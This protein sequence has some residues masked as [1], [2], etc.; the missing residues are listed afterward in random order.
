M[1]TPEILHS[2]EGTPAFKEV[3]LSREGYFVT[4]YAVNRDGSVHAG[5]LT[6]RPFVSLQDLLDLS[7]RDA[8]EGVGGLFGVRDLDLEPILSGEEEVPE[9]VRDMF[10]RH[11]PAELLELARIP[12][13]EDFNPRLNYHLL[14]DR[15]ARRQIVT[16]LPAIR[17]L[18]QGAPKGSRLL[19][20]VDARKSPEAELRKEL[21]MDEAAFKQIRRVL[22]VQSKAIKGG[23][24]SAWTV[25]DYLNLA[26]LAKILTPNHVVETRKDLAFVVAGA[27]G[28]SFA[29]SGPAAGALS[30]KAFRQAP[31][32]QWAEVSAT[33][34]ALPISARD[35]TNAI[36][37]TLSASFLVHLMRTHAPEAASLLGRI[38]PQVIDGQDVGDDTE[39]Q[40]AGDCCKTLEKLQYD[41]RMMDGAVRDILG[42][43]LSIKKFREYAERWHHNQAGMRQVAMSIETEVEWKPLVGTLDLGGIRFREL[44]SNKH[45]ERQGR[46]QNNCVGGYTDVLI[47]AT[48][49]KLDLIFSVETAGKILSTV[50]LEGSFDEAGKSYIWSVGEHSGHSNRS[51]SAAAENAVEG[52]IEELDRLPADRIAD[53]G[54]AMMRKEGLPQRISSLMES[55][56]ANIF[57]PGL[58]EKLLNAHDAVLPKK[59]RGLAVQDWLAAMDRQ[60]DR[61]E[62]IAGAFRQMEQRLQ[63]IKEKEN[64]RE[65]QP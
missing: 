41:L 25:L 65:Y 62:G 51:P 39:L 44:H 21:N 29:S 49:R 18:F 31:V 11:V 5:V 48:P 43:N 33:L 17:H 35:Y 20:L 28:F 3:I 52:L 37:K 34:Q 27:K 19:E 22:A 4:R 53:Y 63:D 45:L 6:A 46:A 56:G 12:S 23:D 57:D 16:A 55:Y 8:E 7:L 60:A 47:N 38:V 1:S 40:A 9:A 26:N 50:R 30:R 14:G 24:A 13:R 64:D 32:E 58:P 54:R 2:K 59:L 42:E 61:F 15:E 10:A 36:H